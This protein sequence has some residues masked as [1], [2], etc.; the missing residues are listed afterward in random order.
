MPNPI[1]EPTVSTIIKS[2]APPFVRASQTSWE[3][4]TPSS[5]CGTRR[6]PAPV[7]AF[8]MTW[9]LFPNEQSPLRPKTAQEFE[10]QGYRRAHEGVHIMRDKAIFELKRYGGAYFLYYDADSG[11]AP[12]IFGSAIDHHLKSA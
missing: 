2:H 12:L 11:A 1:T 8:R 10:E 4:D 3:A 6:V 9:S 7:P 5:A